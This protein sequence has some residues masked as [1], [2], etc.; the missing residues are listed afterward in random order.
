MATSFDAIWKK[1]WEGGEDFR[2]VLTFYFRLSAAYYLRCCEYVNRK[3]EKRKKAPILLI[4]L[5][6]SLSIYVLSW[7]NYVT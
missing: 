7:S 6:L 3:K 1:A 4:S 5:S 2:S